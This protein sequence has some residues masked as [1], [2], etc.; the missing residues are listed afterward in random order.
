ME[1][2]ISVKEIF[3]IPRPIGQPGVQ[4]LH[5][6]TAGGYSFPSGHTQSTSFIVTSTMVEIKKRWFYILGVILIFLVALSR[7][8]LGVHTFKDVVVGCIIGVVWVLVSNRIFERIDT[9]E[10]KHLM[11]V[12]LIPTT[13]GMFF[14]RT[15]TFYKAVGVLTSLVLGYILDAKYIHYDSKAPLWKQI[16][17][18]AIGISVLTFL[19]KYEK[20]L[21]P[22]TLFSGFI[23]YFIMGLWTFTLAPL[24]FGLFYLDKPQ[25]QDMQM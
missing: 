15:G 14:F 19:Q 12:Y 2:S 20:I 22:D 17:K 18:F 16:I 5:T 6:E 7:L 3:K 4:S 23:R 10:E 11:A 24:L 8:Y 25:T 21:L 13:L 1:L 9:S